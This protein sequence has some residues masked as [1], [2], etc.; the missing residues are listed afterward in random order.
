M[1]VWSIQEYTN[2]VSRCYWKKRL[3]KNNII[4]KE[5]KE[6]E[7]VRNSIKKTV[8]LID[9]ADLSC[10]VLVGND[11]KLVKIKQV[12]Y[13]KLHALEKDSSIGTHDPVKVTSYLIL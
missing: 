1:V 7:I 9:F 13:N 4:S 5:K 10:L 11:R 2:N 6:S 12:H 8:S 3:T